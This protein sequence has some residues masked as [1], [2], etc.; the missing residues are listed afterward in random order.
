MLD[1]SLEASENVCKFKKWVSITIS[2]GGFSCCNYPET[3]A[4][5]SKKI[6]FTIGTI[7][8]GSNV[9]LNNVHIT[10]NSLGG[11]IAGYAGQGVKELSSGGMVNTVVYADPAGPY[12]DLIALAGQTGAVAN[13]ATITVHFMSDPGLLGSSMLSGH[14]NLVCLSGLQQTT[15]INLHDLAKDIYVLL[16]K[17]KY[18]LWPS[19]ILSTT[20]VS[21]T[22]PQTSGMYPIYIGNNYESNCK[23]F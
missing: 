4:C 22:S 18:C 10:G 5:H 13:A 6:G 1:W 12:F 17:N 19:T 7:I 14:I 16:T 8:V 20:N 23:P 15:T 2:I 9:P 3:A 11:Q 21:M